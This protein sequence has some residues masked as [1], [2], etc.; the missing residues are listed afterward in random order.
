MKQYYLYILAHKKG[1]VLYVG[2]TNNIERRISEHKS[3]IG[4][5]FSSKYNVTKLVY[6]ETFETS[7]AAFKKERQM[8]K[9][10]R[11]WKIALIEE[12]NPDWKD[13]AEDWCS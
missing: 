6:F 3:G 10:K 8:K 12:N 4:G 11:E 7:Y 1:G 2:F 5:K 13:L 9:W